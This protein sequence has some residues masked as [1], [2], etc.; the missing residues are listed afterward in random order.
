MSKLNWLFLCAAFVA[1]FVAS[2]MMAKDMRGRLVSLVAESESLG[3][4]RGRLFE[5]CRRMKTDGHLDTDAEAA[6]VKI[7][8]DIF[9]PTPT[10]EAAS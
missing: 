6:C 9:G 3:F 10:R 5:R 2:S 4:E 1:V 7:F 8:P